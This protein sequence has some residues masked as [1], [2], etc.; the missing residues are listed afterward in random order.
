MSGTLDRA[1]FGFFALPLTV[2]VAIMVAVV[3]VAMKWIDGSAMPAPE[4]SMVPSVKFNVLPTRLKV[5]RR[6]CRPPSGIGL[7]AV[8][9]M[10]MVPPSSASR[11]RPRT[12]TCSGAF[13]VRFSAIVDGGCRSR[14]GRG[15]RVG[16]ANRQDSDAGRHLVRNADVGAPDVQRATG[17][18]VAL[19]LAL[20]RQVGVD[21]GGYQV[22]RQ[23]AG[24]VGGEMQIDRHRAG[25]T[26]RA[27]AADRPGAG[28]SG[29]T[30]QTDGVARGLD[31]SRQDY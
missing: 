14:R 20:H 22:T 15:R 3:D 19:H 26:D 7:A 23:R 8:P 27:G 29:E 12:K 24:V 28:L 16:V 17:L 31:G 5:P 9:W 11:P 4:K 6:R 21:R 10:W 18:Q 30:G 13:S 25:Q 2:S 1:I